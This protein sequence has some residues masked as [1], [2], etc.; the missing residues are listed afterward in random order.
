M[1][2]IFICRPRYAKMYSKRAAASYYI[3]IVCEYIIYRTVYNYDNIKHQRSIFI[4][5]RRGVNLQS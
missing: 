2:I 3:Y 1:I 5:K 4:I